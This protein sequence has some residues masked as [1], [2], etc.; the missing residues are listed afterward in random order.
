MVRNP[1]NWGAN[2][3]E[4]FARQLEWTKGAIRAVPCEDPDKIFPANSPFQ[5]Y[6]RLKAICS[7]AGSRVEV[8]DPYVD[9]SVFHRYL[10]E[11]PASVPIVVVAGDGS[12]KDRRR[13][14]LVAVSQLFAAERSTTYRF[15]VSAGLHDRHLRADST[16]YHVGG[17][18]KDAAAKSPFSL[19]KHSST[20]TDASLDGIIAGA[21]EWFGP[22]TPKHRRR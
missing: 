11:V 4:Y 16:I 3:Q 12:M 8:F 10:A 21:V 15:L 1:S 18:L 6:L 9:A 20:E 7:T 13:R 5:T 2:A 19:S 14:E 17:S 22:S